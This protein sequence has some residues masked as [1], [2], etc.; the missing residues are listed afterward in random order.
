[1]PIFDLSYPTEVKGVDNK[2][3]NPK[4]T[5]LNKEEYTIYLRKVAEM[6]NKNFERFTNDASAEVKMGAP[7]LD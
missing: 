6:F 3:L 5:W 4:N 7:R 1:M 2:I